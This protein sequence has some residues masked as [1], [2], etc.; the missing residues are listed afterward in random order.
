MAVAV[1]LWVPAQAEGSGA[2]S[3]TG[4]GD[5]GTAADGGTGGAR[6][7]RARQ[8]PVQEGMIRWV[9]SMAPVN[10]STSTSASMSETNPV[11]K[12]GQEGGRAVSGMTVLRVGVPEGLVGVLEFAR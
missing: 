10:A 2:G 6:R 12:L 4:E 8:Q 11:G 5:S 7:K 1:A 9:S 3:G